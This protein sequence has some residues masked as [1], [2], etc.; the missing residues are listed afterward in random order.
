M[1]TNAKTLFSSILLLILSGVASASDPSF[2]CKKASSDIERSICSQTILGKLDQEMSEKYFELKNK[3]VGE[4]LSLLINTQKNWLV[5]RGRVCRQIFRHKECLTELYTKRIELFKHQLLHEDSS[6]VAKYDIYRM[7]DH[8]PQWEDNRLIFSGYNKGGNNFDVYEL[9]PVTGKEEAII[10]DKHAAKFIARNEKYLIVSEKGRMANPLV[11]YNVKTGEKIKQI[12]LRNYINWAKIYN[13]QLV[14]I[15]GSRWGRNETSEVTFFSLPDLKVTKT[16]SIL[17]GNDIQAWKDNIVSIGYSI[18]IYDSNFNKVAESEDL[19]SK[20]PTRNLSCSS[21]P[22]RVHKDKAVAVSTCGDIRIYNLPSLKLERIIPSFSNH[23]TLA[24]DNDL[25]FSAPHYKDGL[26]GGTRVFDIN[27]GSQIAVLPIQATDLFSID[28]KLI[29]VKRIFATRSEISVYK[30]DQNML[31]S[32]NARFDKVRAA[33][34]KAVISVDKGG[35][36]Y[37]A[38]EICNSAAIKGLVNENNLPKDVLEIIYRYAIWLSETYDQYSQATP[39]FEYVSKFMGKV[40]ISSYIETI[41]LKEKI[42]GNKQEVNVKESL[43]DS[44]PFSQVLSY[45]STKAKNRNVDFGAFTRLFKFH[46]DKI[47]IGRWGSRNGHRHVDSASSIAVYDRKTLTFIDEA[48][49]VPYD[50]EYQDTIRNIAIDN[51]YIYLSIEYRYD[52]PDRVNFVILDKESLKILKELHVDN[53]MDDQ[54]TD[55]PY[56]FDEKLFCNTFD[57]VQI[58]KGNLVDYVC[59]RKLPINHNELLKRNAGIHETIKPHA[60]TKNYLVVKGVGRENRGNLTFYY[61]Y[62]PEDPI[63]YYGNNDIDVYSLPKR[64][65]LLIKNKGGNGAYFLYDVTSGIK[66]NIIKLKSLHNKT[67]AIATNDHFIFIGYGRDLIIINIDDHK[68]VRYI[69]GYISEGFESNGHGVDVNKISR[70]IVDNDRLIALTFS[71]VNTRLAKW[72]DLV[73]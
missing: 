52:D 19:P 64:D 45:G 55:S 28:N 54:I 58:E 32:V 41:K 34:K 6:L 62:K 37:E 26:S 57:L 2:D 14:I 30:Y 70:V 61:K 49:I 8:A 13:N 71:G 9:D 50:P 56:L 69:S 10:K 18:S 16:T 7:D 25:I 27:T 68:V 40:E 11:V 29:A 65:E 46:E 42:L 1:I 43:L 23:V 33:Y 48:D 24:V 5:A 63:S 59:V 38:I 22:I 66:K 12:K 73:E 17:G 35:D 31:R 67:P 44:S 72:E 36:I 20:N 60:S 3:V 15:Q 21:G 53:F 47:Y 4:D 39:V 51:N